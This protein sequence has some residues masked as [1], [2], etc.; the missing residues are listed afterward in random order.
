[1]MAAG[2]QSKYL[3]IQH[4]RNRSQRMVVV[5]VNICKRPDDTFCSQSRFNIR[6]VI[7]VRIVIERDE[8]VVKYRLIR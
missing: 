2:V 3:A 8:A 5:G 1:M 4:M 6:I 7:N